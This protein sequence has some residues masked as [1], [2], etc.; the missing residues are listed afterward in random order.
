SMSLLGSSQAPLP[1]AL[2]SSEDAYPFPKD[3]TIGEA[4]IV[5]KQPMNGLRLERWTVASPLMQRN[6]DVQIMRSV[7]AGAPA[8]MLYMLDGIGGN[9]T[10]SGWIN[11]GEGP[12]VFGDENVTVVMP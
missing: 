7:D 10:S 3:P 5:D 4:E 9:K 11:Q 6:V 8:P 2:T 1:G 12:K